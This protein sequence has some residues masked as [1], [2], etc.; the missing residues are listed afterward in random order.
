MEAKKSLGQHWL[1]DEAALDAIC[2]SADL[3]RMDT[4]LEVG[5]GLGHLTQ[6]LV[7]AAGQVI[8]VEV[9]EAL[10]D[11]L[12]KASLPNLKIIKQDILKL[13]LSQLPAGYKVVANIPYYLTSNLIRILS[14]SP[15]PPVQM[16]L[17]VQKEVAERLAAAP[18]QMSLLGVSAQLYYEPELGRVVPAELFDPPP[19]IDSQVIVLHRRQPPLFKELDTKL[20]F[21]I[22]KAGFAGRRKKLRGSL[23][24]GLGIDKIQADELLKSAGISGDLRAQNLKLEDWHKLYTAVLKLNHHE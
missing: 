21:R 6:K 2:Q 11:D 4:V 5:P 22:V 14:E 8:A 19:K 24:A 12:V 7:E 1:K 3:T 23:A 17:L 13:D 16:S 9:D 18:G 20:F 15:N 10:A